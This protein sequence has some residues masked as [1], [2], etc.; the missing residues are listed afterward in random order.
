MKKIVVG[1]LICMF[2]IGN[3]LAI[4]SDI[5]NESY[6]QGETMLI[7]LE[8][9]IL[10]ALSADNVKFYRGHVEIPL[11]YDLKKL[12]DNYY[13][14]AIAPVSENNYSLLVEDIT[15]TISGVTAKVNY[16]TNFSISGDVVDYYI[17]PGF[18][19]SS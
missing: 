8:G 13:I 15:T 17:K 5:K 16:Q 18:I 3:A 6:A 2:L 11:E 10:S 19:F 9:N 4:S 1:L 7:K 14:W 12:G